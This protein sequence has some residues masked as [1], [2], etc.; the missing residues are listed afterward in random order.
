MLSCA[1]FHRIK[2]FRWQLRTQWLG[3]MEMKMADAIGTMHVGVSAIIAALAPSALATHRVTRL[4]L[5][6]QKRINLNVRAVL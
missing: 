2:V 1:E 6:I 4:H 5:V 3:A